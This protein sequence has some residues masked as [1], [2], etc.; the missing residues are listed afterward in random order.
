[1]RYDTMICLPSCAND[2]NKIERNNSIMKPTKARN[3]QYFDKFRR[4]MN[5]LAYSV[6]KTTEFR[7]DKI[8]L[9]NEIL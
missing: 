4:K 7:D 2:N 3:S 9:E 6:D 8:I 5:N 1:M